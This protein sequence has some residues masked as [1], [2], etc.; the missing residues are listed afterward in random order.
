MI[1]I[2]LFV[3]LK[4][5]LCEEDY[6]KFQYIFGMDVNNISDINELAPKNSTAKVELLGD[7]DPKNERTIRDP[8][9]VSC[10]VWLLRLFLCCSSIII[11]NTLFFYE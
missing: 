2:Y 1:Y 5:Q 7:Y 6:T 9:Y 4:L 3:S 10:Q 8:Y 11:T